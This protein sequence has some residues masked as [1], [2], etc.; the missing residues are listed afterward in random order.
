MTSVS[1]DC[2]AVLARG[3]G[4]MKGI[5]ISLSSETGIFQKIWRTNLLTLFIFH[6]GNIQQPHQRTRYKSLRLN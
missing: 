1:K 3:H 5:R 4:D 2:I 6:E